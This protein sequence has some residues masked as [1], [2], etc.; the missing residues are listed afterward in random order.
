[1]EFLDFTEAITLSADFEVIELDFNPWN[2]IRQ[3]GVELEESSIDKS[4]ESVENK[5]KLPN[6]VV[7]KEEFVEHKLA[8]QVRVATKPSFEDLGVVEHRSAIVSGIKPKP[9][10]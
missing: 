10:F 7:V 1:M 2:L 3:Q 5:Y 4:R 6:I 9:Y 8:S